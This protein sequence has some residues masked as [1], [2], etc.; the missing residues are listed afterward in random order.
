MSSGV[1]MMGLDRDFENAL[2]STL[3]ELSIEAVVCVDEHQNI[4]LFNHRAMQV[5]GYTCDE[6]VGR[7]MDMLMP[8]EYRAVHRQKMQAFIACDSAAPDMQQRT[9]VVGLRGN[10]EQFPAETSVSKAHING[11]VLV[12][13]ILQDITEHKLAHEKLA[14]QASY[15]ALTSLPNRVLLN[16]RLEHAFERARRDKNRVAV[17]F[18]D[19]D[20]FKN[21]NDSLGYAVG[22]KL[23]VEV[24]ERLVSRLREEDTIGRLIG[25][26]FLIIMEGLSKA[27]DAGVL[28]HKLAD[29]FA[30]PFIIEGHELYMSTSIGISIFPDDGERKSALISHADVA[31]FQANKD[32]KNSYRFYLNEL[33]SAAVERARMESALRRALKQNELIVYYQPQVS[34]QSGEIIGAEALIRWQHPE[35]GMVSPAKF[36][37]LAEECGLIVPIGE[38]DLRTAC[39]QMATW[40]KR[41]FA[42]KLVAVNIA[43]AQITRIDLV[44]L[45]ATVLAETGLE[46]QCLELEI[47][48]GFV[49][50]DPRHAIRLLH[51]LK[52]L[53]VV[54]AID[55]FGTG[56][57]S[58]AYLK[59]FPI[60]K[61]KIDQAFVRNVTHD[62][63]DDAIVRAIITLGHALELKVIAEG[64]E[65]LEQQD[66]LRSERC[67][68]GQGYYYG[69]P[70]TAE[71]L[72]QLLR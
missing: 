6:V 66:F 52:N 26:E 54:L 60:D 18:L 59:Q 65:T 25:D 61:L 10:G 57:S 14:H 11:T 55:D 38:W 67:N 22:D 72:E 35:M 51:E 43:G 13:S 68:E 29:S 56:H 36:I 71:A 37:P 23:L 15:D 9:E 2:L 8:E 7:P 70:V 69:R 39:A 20:R 1:L 4:I 34:L 32:D 62:S 30:E 31:M 49:M 40:K 58:L 48:E 17:L 42:L 12:I 27:E 33:T 19:L 45:V 63:Q 16:D 3:L 47:T 46:P 50:G 24:S 21:V 44:D 41:G 28:A 64:I 53:G 5:F